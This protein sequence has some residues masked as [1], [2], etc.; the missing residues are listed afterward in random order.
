[1]ENLS[2]CTPTEL[3]KMVND[4]Q[5]RHESLKQEIINHTIEIDELDKK[6][7]QKIVMLDELE[8]NYIALIEEISNR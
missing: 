4:V 3:L 5:A 1:M 7:N 8:K 6:V 2:G